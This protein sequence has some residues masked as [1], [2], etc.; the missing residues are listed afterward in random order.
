MEMVSSSWLQTK[1]I[2]FIIGD[3]NYL[4]VSLCPHTAL[5]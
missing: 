4:S 2:E 3:N 1:L 5:V